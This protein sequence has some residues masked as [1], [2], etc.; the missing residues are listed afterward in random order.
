MQVLTKRSAVVAFASR[1]LTSCFHAAS[2]PGSSAFFFRQ[3]RAV[4][5]AQANQSLRDSSLRSYTGTSDQHR[6]HKKHS[7]ETL[8]TGSDFSGGRVELCVPDLVR[9]QDPLH[10]EKLLQVQYWHI[11]VQGIDC[12]VLG[13]PEISLRAAKGDSM[14]C[15]RIPANSCAEQFNMISHASYIAR[16]SILSKRKD[17]LTRK[18]A[19]SDIDGWNVAV[20]QAPMRRIRVL[21]VLHLACREPFL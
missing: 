7:V 9:R 12:L 6:K 4:P 20:S 13:P 1:V 16:L 18:T 5:P 14:A 10:G 8:L 19:I 21:C 15:P 2:P 17:V 3:D 11:K